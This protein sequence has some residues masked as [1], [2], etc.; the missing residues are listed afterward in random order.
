M[1]CHYEENYWTALIMLRESDRHFFL[2]D[3]VRHCL[4]LLLCLASFVLTTADLLENPLFKIYVIKISVFRRTS[5]F[6][7]I[8]FNTS[9]E[10]KNK[11]FTMI[12]MY[13]LFQN[14]LQ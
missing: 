4:V 8:D 12:Q 3:Q 9:M 2:I 5:E 11:R 13:L 1:Q 14:T 10:H 6:L 7:Y